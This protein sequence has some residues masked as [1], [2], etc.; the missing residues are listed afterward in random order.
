VSTGNRRRVAG[1]K[2]TSASGPKRQLPDSAGPK[3]I[4]TWRVKSSGGSSGSKVIPSSSNSDPNSSLVLATLVT[5]TSPT[6]F[7]STRTRCG[8]DTRRSGPGWVLGGAVPGEVDSG[9]VEP[10]TESSPG[11]EVATV[12]S[13]PPVVT[14]GG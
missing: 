13:G 3:W 5:H 4:T 10:G 7:P 6:E 8:I 12:R 1:S 9:A 11:W 14:V 2:T